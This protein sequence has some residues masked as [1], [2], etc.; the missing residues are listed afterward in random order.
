MMDVETAIVAFSV[1]AKEWSK[2]QR[3]GYFLS[4]HAFISHRDLL[5]NI[6]M[7]RH[8][9]KAACQFFFVITMFVTIE[10]L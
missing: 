2:L 8:C 3:V 7:L 1:I 9:T 4:S 6:G 5:S 10:E